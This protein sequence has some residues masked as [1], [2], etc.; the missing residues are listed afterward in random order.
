[1]GT[2]SDNDDDDDDDDDNDDDVY[3]DNTFISPPRLLWSHKA[4]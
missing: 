4:T 3:N 2:S 1:M